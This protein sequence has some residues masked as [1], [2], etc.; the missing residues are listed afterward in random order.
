MRS[1][2]LAP[3]FFHAL[4]RAHRLFIFDLLCRRAF[5]KA[6][7]QQQRHKKEKTKGNE[8]ILSHVGHG[9][10]GSGKI[11]APPDQD[12]RARSPMDLERPKGAHVAL[13]RHRRQSFA[14]CSAHQPREEEGQKRDFPG[15]A[16]RGWLPRAGKSLEIS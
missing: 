9:G 11:A 8:P 10:R 15:R 2:P 6:H 14:Q 7:H 5:R 4:F 13:H 12:Q 16:P 3:I 1:L